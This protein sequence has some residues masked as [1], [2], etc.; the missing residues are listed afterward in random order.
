MAEHKTMR[1]LSQGPMASRAP[2]FGKPFVL[3]P[4]LLG[5]CLTAVGLAS[6]ADLHREGYDPDCAFCQF[7]QHTHV[8][9]ALVPAPPPLGGLLN[10]IE[11]AIDVADRRNGLYN[12]AGSRAPPRDV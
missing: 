4:L 10:R 3:W 9:T 8:E 5:L 1:A 6:V 2:G 7:H 11:P 12:S